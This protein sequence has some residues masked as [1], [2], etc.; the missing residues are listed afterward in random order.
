MTCWP[1]DAP[2]GLAAKAFLRALAAFDQASDAFG[3]RAG[4]AIAGP[5][6][7]GDSRS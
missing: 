1:P 7:G 5:V 2:V 6:R 4:K 3:V